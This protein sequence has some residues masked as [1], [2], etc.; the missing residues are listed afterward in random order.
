MLFFSNCLRVALPSQLIFICA[1]AFEH[2]Y[3]KMAPHPK[4]THLHESP[5]GEKKKKHPINV[6]KY[7]Y[8]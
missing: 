6:S 2:F 4:L 7:F 1:P 8:G 3:H 5:T